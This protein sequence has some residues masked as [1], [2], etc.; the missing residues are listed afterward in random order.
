MLQKRGIRNE[1]GIRK[2]RRGQEIS[3]NLNIKGNAKKAAH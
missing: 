1:A 2:V 3:F